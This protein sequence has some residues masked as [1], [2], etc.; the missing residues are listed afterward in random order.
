MFSIRPTDVLRLTAIT[1]D[2]LCPADANVYDIEF[3]R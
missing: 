1:N 3:T 2:Y